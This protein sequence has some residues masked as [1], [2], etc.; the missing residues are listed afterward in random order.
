M[1]L[2]ILAPVLAVLAA[3]PALAGA[4]SENKL[5]PKALEG[6][7][8]QGSYSSD[9]GVERSGSPGPAGPGGQTGNQ[10]NTQGGANG[11][12]ASATGA[13]TGTAGDGSSGSASP[14]AAGGANTSGSS[15][16]E[17]MQGDKQ[18]AGEAKPNPM[19]GE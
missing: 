13:S 10:T 11:S 17:K 9:P 4:S 6:P 8:G 19:P 16:T 12:G 3:G 1:K 2:Y 14:S 18:P 5:D 15:T 7:G